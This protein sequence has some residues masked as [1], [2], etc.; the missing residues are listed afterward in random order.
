MVAIHC[1]ISYI[2][3]FL[4]RTD[5]YSLRV[6]LH[7][8]L[9][10][11]PM[12][13]GENKAE[14]IRH[15]KTVG[16]PP[17]VL[18]TPMKSMILICACVCVCSCVLCFTGL[19]ADAQ[20]PRPGDLPIE[21]V[22]Q[23]FLT[24]PSF[25]RTPLF[26]KERFPNIVVTAKGTVLATFGSQSVRARRSED[27]G[28]NWGPPI[29]IADPGFHGGGLTVDENTGHIFAFA[30]A[31]HPPSKV[32]VFRSS[33]DGKTWQPLRV[34]IKPNSLGHTPSMHMNEH[35]ITLR[36]GPHAG[37]LIRPTRY[38]GGGN[39][40]K[41]WSEHYT[42]AMYSDDH[43]KTWQT[44]EPFPEMGNGEAAIAELSDGRLYYNTRTHWAE[45]QQPIRRHE[46]WSHD[47]GQTWQD[48]RIIDMLPDG[49]QD[50]SYGCMGGLTRL[51][52]AGK[53]ILI[54][55]N[56]DTP[57]KRRER[58]TVWASFDGG[59]TWP[60][61]RL[62]HEGPSRYSSLASGRPGTPSQGWIFLHFEGGPDGGS[63][64]AR[65]NLTWLIGGTTTGD[66]EIPDW[67]Q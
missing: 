3:L 67:V 17:V 51:P 54:F 21:G 13:S 26:D 44:S 8:L 61:K 2:A 58:A 16:D 52:V 36:H 19:S 31:K 41:L 12:W 14:L 29:T 57:N 15:F 47:G 25:S 37:R 27:G 64:V 34:T 62:V 20:Q 38:Y 66:G 45:A 7:E 56:I 40:R 60:V 53:D 32:N 43:G 24:E 35:G 39:D 65:F 5:V 22:C 4:H 18:Q 28:K 23:P 49:R 42:N 55:S 48:F 11:Q 9:T 6:T 50:R 59:T 10:L 63:S 30:E 1:G 33:D 46:A